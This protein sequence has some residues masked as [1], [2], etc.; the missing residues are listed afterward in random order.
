LNSDIQNLPTNAVAGTV[1]KSGDV[2]IGS[3][4]VANGALTAGRTDMPG[5]TKVVTQGITLYKRPPSVSFQQASLDAY[6]V[7]SNN[8]FKFAIL[9]SCGNPVSAKPVVPP[10]APQPKP[11]AT[12]QCTSLTLDK[13]DTRQ[14]KATVAFTTTG[15]ATLKSITYDFGDNTTIPPTTETSKT[16]TYQRDGNFTVSATL[17]FNSSNTQPLSATCQQMIT[18]STPPAPTPPAPS[19]PVTPVSTPPKALPS[20]GPAG[21]ASLFLGTSALGTFGYRAFLRRHLNH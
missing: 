5:S 16:H 8:Q 6:V 17:A 7:M 12:A 19:P 15:G 11:Q 21:L 18:V 9:A 4:L 3:K 10:P 20:T 14:Y 2:M 13:V 1:T